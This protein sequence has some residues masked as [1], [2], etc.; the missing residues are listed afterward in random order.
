MVISRRVHIQIQKSEKHWNWDTLC[1][2]CGGGL[3]LA[4]DPD[5]DRVV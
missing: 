4:T 5:C 3:L 2:E 1:K